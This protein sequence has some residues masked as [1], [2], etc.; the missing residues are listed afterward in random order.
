MITSDFSTFPFE[1]LQVGR[2]IK[3]LFCKRIL[4]MV[5]DWR[6]RVIVAQKSKSARL[7]RTHWNIPL[8]R[9]N[10]GEGN[11]PLN[12]WEHKL[13][14]TIYSCTSLRLHSPLSGG[15]S[16]L[17]ICQTLPLPPT[18]PIMYR[19]NYLLI[20][21]FH[22]TFLFGENFEKEIQL[23]EEEWAGSTYFAAAK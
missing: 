22:C 8:H 9:V 7:H 6:N 19:N 13:Y 3:H 1:T 14:S 4:K 5:L 11:S 2:K 17:I 16:T 10:S 18:I 23:V 15:K 21:H 20:S 12:C